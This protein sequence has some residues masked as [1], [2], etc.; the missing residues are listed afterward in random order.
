MPTSHGTHHAY[1]FPDMRTYV[2][3]HVYVSWY[4]WIYDY[5]HVNIYI[6]DICIYICMYEF[7]VFF[8]HDVPQEMHRERC[9]W[10][11]QHRRECGQTSLGTPLWSWM[12]L[13]TSTGTLLASTHYGHM[14]RH[15]NSNTYIHRRDHIYAFRV[16]VINTYKRRIKLHNCSLCSE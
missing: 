3:M 1:L 4:A 11:E 14:H 7:L 9:T 16:I 5:I 8:E 12:C 2:Y 6:F 10:H 15:T 13:H